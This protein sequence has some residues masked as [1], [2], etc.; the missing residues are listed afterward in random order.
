[1]KNQ[2]RK[3]PFRIKGTATEFGIFKEQ[4]QGPVQLELPKQRT[5]WFKMKSE[6]QGGTRL[7]VMQRAGLSNYN[8]R[9]QRV[10]NG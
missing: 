4:N 1:M 9:C 6:R 10:F 3:E 2:E 5:E 7:F 8:V